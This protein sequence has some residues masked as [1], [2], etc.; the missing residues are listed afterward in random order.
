[1]LCN[2]FMKMCYTGGG[3][4]ET[5]EESAGSEEDCVGGRQVPATAC[6]GEHRLCLVLCVSWHMSPDLKTTILYNFDTFDTSPCCLIG[7][8]VG[9]NL[10]VIT[11]VHHDSKDSKIG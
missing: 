1:M 5:G 10:F 9:V 11:M 3:C 6:D 4:R 8:V 2:A 7:D